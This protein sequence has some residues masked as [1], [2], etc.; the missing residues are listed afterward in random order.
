M[1]AIDGPAGAGKSTLAKLLAKRLGFCLLDTGALYRVMALHLGRLGISAET[2]E[3][4]EAALAAL[5][6]RIEPNPE[7]MKLFLG[8]EDVSQ[9]IRNEET[10]NLASRFSARPEV[11]KALLGVQRSLGE[12]MNLVAEGRDMGTIVFPDAPVKFFMVADL[13]QR[14]KRRYDELEANGHKV[15]LAD[16]LQEMRARDDRDES[17]SEAPLVKA[18]DA[19]VVDTTSLSREQVLEIMMNHIELSL[20]NTLALP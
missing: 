10:G 7:G 1:I 15:L 18:P 6:M 19:I 11:R 3:I 2:K 8:N 16:V 9:L 4:Q 13:N 14:A 5:N 12:R 17:R 20:K